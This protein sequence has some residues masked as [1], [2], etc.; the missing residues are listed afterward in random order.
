MLITAL[1]RINI[2]LWLIGEFL[3]LDDQNEM[4]GQSFTVNSEPRK[5]VSQKFKTMW[6]NYLGNCDVISWLR[7][8]SIY[9]GDHLMTWLCH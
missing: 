9:Q 8:T 4:G 7:N 5:I 1:N 6:G 2:N 3:T